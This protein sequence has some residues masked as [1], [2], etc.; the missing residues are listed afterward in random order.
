MTRATADLEAQVLAWIEGKRPA[1]FGETVRQLH[2]WQ[3]R[4][5]APYRQ[6]CEQAG[7]GETVERWRQV[8]SVPQEAF[9]HADLRSFPV[10]ETIKTF[11]TSGTTGEGF[12]QHH[13]R[14]LEIYETAVR[15]GWRHAN[16]PTGPF[17]VIAPHPDQAPYSSLSHMLGVLAPR[18][19]FIAAGGTVDLARLQ[20]IEHP[21][22]LLGTA[23]GFLNLFEQM[24]KAGIT[25]RLPA[26]STAMET[27]GYK[28]SG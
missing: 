4:H 26:G 16:M 25:L 8:P 2:G 9:K 23:L 3:F 18:E 6:F 12:G 20:A 24:D 19:L 22:C 27:G 14:T 21:V 1:D 17:L 15:E 5:N 10:E 28:G 7:I 13:F 11:R